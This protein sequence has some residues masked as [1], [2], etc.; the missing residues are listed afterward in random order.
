MKILQAQND[1][2]LKMRDLERLADA[3]RMDAALNTLQTYI[4]DGQDA[5]KRQTEHEKVTGKSDINLYVLA[6]VVVGGF[7][8]LTAFLIL[9]A[10]YSK[11][12]ADQSGV[13]YMLLGT[14]STAFG[15][16]MG[17]FFGKNKDS[18]AHMRTA[19]SSIHM[20]DVQKLMECASPPKK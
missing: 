7:L 20:D 18:E 17:Y 1:F 12:I 10:Y 3:Q 2:A 16:V 6:W 19:S 8:G 5:R 15:M 14:L 9:C 4:A 13:L 11:P